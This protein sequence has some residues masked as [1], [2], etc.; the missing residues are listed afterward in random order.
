[1]EVLATTCERRVSVDLTARWARRG[2]IVVVV[3]ATVVVVVSTVV[4]VP[5]PSSAVGEMTVA[6]AGS[7]VVLRTI[8]TTR[9]P[10]D[11]IRTERRGPRRDVVERPL[12][13]PERFRP[14]VT[15]VMDQL[16]KINSKALP[17]TPQHLPKS[18]AGSRRAL[19][20]DMCVEFSTVDGE[21][22]RFVKELRVI[23]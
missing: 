13:S 5:Y 12:G 14:C 20:D 2:A 4:V 19:V 23:G 11:P 8:P 9:E 16:S 21:R 1:V 22:E 3:V 10:I 17:T 6:M 7:A 18:D 15:L